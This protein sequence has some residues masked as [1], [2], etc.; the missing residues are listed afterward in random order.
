MHQVR[1]AGHEEERGFPVQPLCLRIPRHRSTIFADT[2]PPLE[3]WFLAVL[4]IVEARKGMS[5]NQLKRTVG[6]SYT[7]S[8]ETV[9]MVRGLLSLGGLSESERTAEML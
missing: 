3:K 5:A 9:R 7:V 6:V 1:R 2:K 4:L 8:L